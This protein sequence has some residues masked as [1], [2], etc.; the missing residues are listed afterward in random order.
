MDSSP[1]CLLFDLSPL[2]L[3]PYPFL[4]LLKLAHSSPLEGPSY[5][6]LR[7]ALLEDVSCPSYGSAVSPVF[8]H[9]N[10]PHT[11][12][13]GPNDCLWN[14]EIRMVAEVKCSF[15]GQSRRTHEVGSKYRLLYLAC[16]LLYMFFRRGSSLHT[17]GRINWRIY[18]M[19]L[20]CSIA[21]VL[22]VCSTGSPISARW[23]RRLLYLTEERAQAS[24]LFHFP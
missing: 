21:F 1:A 24:Y 8:L 10:S 15:P 5:R 22:R 6:S 2:L 12:Y 13:L 9:L 11:S 3:W 20:I 18:L 14:E 4:L 19:R 16:P 23:N 7:K 17:P